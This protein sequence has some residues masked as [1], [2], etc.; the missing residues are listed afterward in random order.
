MAIE[1]LGESL[2]AQ[3]RSKRKKEEKKGKIFGAVLLGSQIGNMFL[4]K[5]AE[6]RANEFWTSNRGLIDKKT[7][8]FQAGMN[9]W[10]DHNNMMKGY[11]MGATDIDW[12]NAFKQKQYDIYKQRELG[13][14]KISELNAEKLK[15]FE[16][17]VNPL[18]EDDVKAYEQKL[19]LFRNF[20]NIKDTEENKK[21][22]LAPVTNKF[23][24]AKKIIDKEANVGSYLLN[25]LGLRE[26]GL[27]TVTVEGQD[28][29]LPRRMSSEQKQV[30]VDNIKLNNMYLKNIDDIDKTVKYTPFTDEQI[31][32]FVST[33]SWK[34]KIPEDLN[35][36]FNRAIGNDQSSVFL[37]QKYSTSLSDR[38]LNIKKIYEQVQK[39]QQAEGADMF[40][41]DVISFAM[42]ARKQYEAN[43]ENRGKP[44]S[45]DYFLNIGM[46]NYI[47]S[48]ELIS[49]K[50]KEEINLREKEE[51]NRQ[52]MNSEIQIGEIKV[53]PLQ[54]QKAFLSGQYTQEQK[55]NLYMQLVKQF[56]NIPQ[57]QGFL[58]N[59]E[60]SI[61]KED[62]EERK[63]SPFFQY[64]TKFRKNPLS[65]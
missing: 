15:E 11:G 37:Q 16:N 14:T 53:T 17:T 59:L 27:E 46:E 31:A 20:E 45:A 42:E 61:S 5:Q 29:L 40:K 63:I 21:L 2:L 30:I 56:E 49:E 38:E 3:A 62:E 50:A 48:S 18:I 10:T 4:R 22:F 32:Q 24:E 28:V 8:Q 34:S 1:Q 7:K 36:A 35:S 12:K 43:P 39:D 51:I 64:E 41:S 65:T 9:F 60:S 13:K 26:T 19:E 57:A 25:K 23:A 52:F 58:N 44:K 54:I 47:I 55:E 33:S 6:K